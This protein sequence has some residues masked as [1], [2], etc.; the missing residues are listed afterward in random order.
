MN[1]NAITKTLLTVWQGLPDYATMLGE[2]AHNHALC[3]CNTPMLTNR[4]IDKI[5]DLNVKQQTIHHLAQRLQRVIAKLPSDTQAVLRSYY[6]VYGLTASIPA[7]AKRLGMAERTFYRHLDRATDYVARHLT[8]LGINFFTWQ[9]L[10]HQHP[11]IKETFMRQC[12]PSPPR[13]TPHRKVLN[14]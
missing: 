4:I 2:R 9:D 13:T 14:H 5:I 11:W 12:P 7:Q 3:S 8:D 1:T 6:Q 10:L